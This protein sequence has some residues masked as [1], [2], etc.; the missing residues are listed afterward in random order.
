MAFQP[1]W[2]RKLIAT[3]RALLG[4]APD[5]LHNTPSTH[6]YQQ[7]NNAGVES[8]MSQ[9]PDPATGTALQG[10]G[11]DYA[12]AQGGGG[13]VDGTPVDHVTGVGQNAGLTTAQAMDQNAA[14]RE[15][16]FGATAARRWMAPVDVDGRQHTERLAQPVPIG[17]LG[18]PGFTE[19]HIGTSPVS[20]PNAQRTGS[21]MHFWRDRVFDRR[22]Y[23]TDHRPLYTPN[24]YAAVD[25]PAGDSQ[26]VSPTPRLGTVHTLL[27]QAPQMRRTPSDS[28]D[29]TITDGSSPAQVSAAPLDVWGL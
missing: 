4:T 27:Q 16:D 15:M 12:D 8:W 2:N 28:A 18:S 20:Y 11:T 29:A 13:P 5:P 24:A 14:E 25:A 19:S 26:Y 1:T 3:N 22:T 6:D 7:S 21:R 10:E 9:V 17:E 23:A